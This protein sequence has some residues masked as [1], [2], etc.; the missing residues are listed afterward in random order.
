M[1][2]RDGVNRLYFNDDE[3]LDEQINTI[4]EIEPDASV[5]YWEADLRQ[6]MVARV[7]E[8]VMQAGRNRCF[9]ADRGRARCEPAWQR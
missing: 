4:A 9:R 5:N 7:L 1:Y 2:W 8:F 6:A 3:V